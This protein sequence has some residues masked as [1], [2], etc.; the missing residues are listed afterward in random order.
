M[1]HRLDPLLRPKSIAVVGASAREDSMG[2]WTLKNIERG[3]YDGDVF[4]INPGYELIGDKPCHAG[5]TDL[6]EVPE[7]AIFAVG[8][9]R[10]EAALDDAIAAGIKAA[11]IMSTLYVD[12]DSDPPLNERVRRK[13]NEASLLVCGANGMGFYNVRDHVWACGFDSTSHE[14]PGNVAII[15][16]S[17]AG[18]SGIIDCEARL[19][20]NFAVS[21][22]NELSV[23]MDQYL[24]F[25]LDL[26]ET[27]VVG[28]FIET[29]RD[30]QGFEAALA[31]AA[32]KRIPIV[33]LKVGRTKKSA[34]LAV[35]H[36][37]ALA[38]DD[39]TYDALFDK[40]GVQRVYDQDAWTTT[41]IMFAH[42]HP[43]GEG[44]LVSL[45]DSG[46]ER[47]LLVDTADKAGVPLA[48]LGNNTV[49]ALEKILDPELPAVNPLDAWSRGGPNAAEVM[50]QSL[51]LMLQDPSAALGAVVHDRAPDGRVY[52]SYLA[53]MQRAKAE[54]GKSVALVSARQGS[55]HDE[56]AVT[57]TH[58][59][60]PV[61][62]GVASF[63][64]GT[65][66]LLAYRDFLLADRADLPAA[67]DDSVRKWHARLS[68]GVTL[69]EY[70]SLQLLSDFGIETA[71]TRTASNVEEVVAV[72]ETI[73]YPVV[74]KTAK[75][76]LIHKSDEGGVVPGIDDEARL[77]EA[78]LEISSRLGDE[79]LVAAMAQPGVEMLLG[80][81]VDKQFGPVVVF[82]FG[83]IHA[84]VLKDVQF[85]MPPFD[86]ATARAALECCR[87][88]PMLDEQRGRPASDIDALC[89]TVARFSVLV[90]SLSDVIGELD[91]NPL[92]ASP[93]GCIA[94]DAVVVGKG[95]E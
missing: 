58:A 19:Q 63:L 12:D 4:L 15:S 34:D 1:E 54:S 71:R 29:A 9:H 30:P 32:N 24:D 3:G 64:V 90:H 75:P 39:A 84:E 79:M 69:S 2:W 77:R 5:F 94:V 43:V 10:L 25:V 65:C 49:A 20:T 59:G 86:V 42:L 60:Y 23:S 11:V 73:G 82:G 80:V 40:Y 95:L 48:D 21:T 37:G 83:G 78:H 87:L 56:A 22:G 27:R 7:L 17:G 38:G 55:G 13:I 62:D 33:A 36:S 52:S 67:N 6:P 74:L 81:K 47:Q 44:A 28:L 85:L 50:T 14:A 92:I 45:H 91:V 8:D 26:P 89:E 18:M 41:L 70:E 46:G 68:H 53:Y 66:A 72:A 93:K 76:G 16:H 57:S 61:L 35:S 31:K 88:R 51:S